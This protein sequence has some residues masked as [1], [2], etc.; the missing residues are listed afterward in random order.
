MTVLCRLAHVWPFK[1]GLKL[2]EVNRSVT[3][4]YILPVQW[5]FG[6]CSESVR[7]LNTAPPPP[8]GPLQNTCQAFEE[9]LR[10]SYSLSL[11]TIT[12][13]LVQRYTTQYII[14]EVTYDLINTP[15]CACL[16]VSTMI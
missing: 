4:D 8:P 1:Y 9:T 15:Y 14:E 10:A 13:L 3:D 7:V 6:A 2:F 11:R 5:L 12:N 16:S